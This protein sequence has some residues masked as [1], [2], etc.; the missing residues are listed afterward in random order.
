MSLDPFT[1]L[2]ALTVTHVL[3]TA[4]LIFAWHI[5]KSIPGVGLWALGRVC[6]T[7]GLVAF[8]LRN[9]IPFNA[10]VLFGNGLLIMGMHFVWLGNLAFM[11]RRPPQLVLHLSVYLIIMAAMA[12]WTVY[13]PSF[14][15]RS[16]LSSLV[17]GGFDALYVRALW[18]RKGDE[19]Y[20]IGKFLAMV[21]AW[22]VCVQ[23]LRVMVSFA[24]G[25]GQ[26]LLEPAL[27]TQIGL[28]NGLSMSMVSAM[29]YMAFIME[30]LKKD[31]VRQ[32][33]RDPLTGAFN[34]RAFRAVAEHILARG[35]REGSAVSLVILDLD[36]FKS[37]NDT[38]GHIAGDMVLK[39]VVDLVHGVLRAQ[40]VLV[41]LGGEE[42]AM[43]LPATAEGEAHHVAERIRM[44]I[45]AELFEIGECAVRITTSLG[46][47]SLSL[48]NGGVE[49]DDLIGR[50]D[51]ALYQAKDAGR[52]MVCIS[53]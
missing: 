35:R 31:L 10:S 37:V 17:I 52:N 13:E 19:I 8:S 4:I 7:F 49:I 24:G 48:Q 29:A 42:F 47:T 9:M 39:R 20:F 51:T 32:A 25:S 16:V 40:D 36:H 50:A 15:A 41:R 22:G 23:T 11:Q 53:V 30:Y 3:A 1:L 2:V 12:Y 27:A 38:Y 18:P 26:A 45:E 6:V 28:L 21:F 33:E 43:L 14:L 5:N 34:R 44:A 46:V